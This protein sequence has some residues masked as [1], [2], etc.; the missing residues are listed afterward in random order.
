MSGVQVPLPLPLLFPRL[1]KQSIILHMQKANKSDFACK[2]VNEVN[3]IPKGKILTYGDI[4]IKIKGNKD[5]SQAVGQAIK[6]ETESNNTFPWWRVVFATMKPKEG[7]KK[8]LK[9]RIFS[10][11][12]ARFNITF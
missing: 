12:M 9:M 1:N 11:T 6:S 7:A 4:S 3:N 10:F 5:S 8:Y 2:V